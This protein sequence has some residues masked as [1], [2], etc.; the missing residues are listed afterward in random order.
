MEHKTLILDGRN[1]RRLI[2]I[3][4]AIKAAEK[5]FWSFGKGRVQMPPKLY[6]IYKKAL[7]SKTGKYINFMTCYV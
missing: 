4:D 3:K 6:I 5:A 7:K 2:D 1:V